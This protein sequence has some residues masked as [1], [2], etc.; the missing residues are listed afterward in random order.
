M[1]ALSLQAACWPR[2]GPD[3]TALSSC[4]SSCHP[5]APDLFPL[6]TPTILA[7]FLL[8]YTTYCGEGDRWR[9]NRTWGLSHTHS[10]LARETTLA[11]MALGS[12]CLMESR[13]MSVRKR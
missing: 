1:G 10:W 2:L 6:P 7:C 11:V 13:M 8:P 3:E 5:S 4:P 9:R 12:F